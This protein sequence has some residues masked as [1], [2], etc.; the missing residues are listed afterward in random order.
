MKPLYTQQEYDNS[1]STQKL[2]CE[3]YQCGD[4]FYKLKKEITSYLNGNPKHSIKY[5]SLKCVGDSNK[6]TKTIK[7]DNCGNN[8]DKLPSEIKRTNNNFCSHSCHITYVN[9]N[10]TQ[11]TRRSKL[12]VWLEEQLTILYPNLPIDFNKTKAISSELDIYIPSLNLAFELNGIF[13]YEPIFGKDKLQQIQ[14]NDQSKSKA[15]FDNE[16]DL[17][18]IDTSGQKYFKPKSSQKYLN[19]ITNI[20]NERLLTS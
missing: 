19:I 18:I 13:H 4:T 10:K 9:K 5:C 14:N 15:C 11:G 8:F 6:A 7:C 20:I 16:I 2:P 17:C 3:C 1:K 12:E